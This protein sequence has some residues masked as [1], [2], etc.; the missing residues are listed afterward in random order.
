M[1]SRGTGVRTGI[2]NKAAFGMCL[3]ATTSTS[4]AGNGNGGALP[5]RIVGEPSFAAASALHRAALAKLV[6]KV[7][8][9]HHHRRRPAYVSPATASLEYIVDGAAPRIVEIA[10]SN[11][12]CTVDGAIGYMT[13]AITMS[14][15]PGTH[16][17]SFTTFDGLNAT[18]NVLSANT[19]VSY[20]VRA[21]AANE[22][23]VTLGGIA[24]SLAIVTTSR[25]ASG[26][27]ASGFSIYGS[28]PVRFSIVPVDADGDFILGPGSPAPSVQ[29][30]P[31][32]TELSTPVPAAPNV[33]TLTSTAPATDPLQPTM[34]SLRVEATPVP[35]SGGGTVSASVGLALYQPWIYV[36]N[37]STIST[38]DEQ[39]NP[40]THTGA[41]SGLSSATAIAYNPN[42]Q[43]LYVTDYTGNSVKTYD[44]Q[45]ATAVCTGCFNSGLNEP[46]GIAYDS[47][48]DWIYVANYGNNSVSA[49]DY[50]GNAVTTSG[51]SGL[52]SP[53][54]V[55]FDPSDDLLYVTGGGALTKSAYLES[56]GSPQVLGGGFGG[57][58]NTDGIAYDAHDGS[59][60]VAADGAIEAFDDQGNARA[61]SGSFA[62]VDRAENALYDPYDGQLYVVNYVGTVTSYD[63]QG[64][65]VLLAS[66]IAVLD[67]AT[68]IAL[69][70]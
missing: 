66:P 53:R 33:W 49:Y 39:G 63:E 18:G 58:S 44:R 46:F 55:A 42:Q 13:C 47:H 30:V 56:G 26:S 21:G 41:F 4:C 23:P 15:A 16:S 48:D 38:F 34:A 60:Y 61:L 70:P 17:F 36:T 29:S 19:T 22:V 31:G 69:V 51:F 20:D 11:P 2:M 40:V 67:Y 12:N 14:L 32:S 5:S 1:T 59:L 10:T 24:A 65:Q 3:L 45:G 35:D 43:L 7:P 54:Y 62:N 28:T 50:L 37:G 25:A 27:Q 9:R 52:E 8:K 64:D 6:I 68:G 57:L